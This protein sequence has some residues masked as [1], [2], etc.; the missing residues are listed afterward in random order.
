MIRS[1]SEPVD[2]GGVEFVC[3]G[4]VEVE[5]TAMFE[6]LGAQGTLVEA[7]CGVENKCVVLEFV[8]MGGGEDAVRAVKRWQEWRHSLVGRRE[9]V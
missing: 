2:D 8:V 4:K 5:A 9:Y 1:E 6:P 7:T 3:V